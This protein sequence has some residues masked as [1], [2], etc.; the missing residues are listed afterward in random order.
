MKSLVNIIFTA[1][2]FLFCS[3]PSFSFTDVN[4][5]LTG[6]LSVGGKFYSMYYPAGGAGF[7]GYH[8]EI[9]GRPLQEIH[10]STIYFHHHNHIAHRFQYRSGAL[11]FEAAPPDTGYHTS[12]MLHF[13]VG[14]R[15]H[16][17]GF[18]SG[19]VTG[20]YPY[21]SA[22]FNGYNIEIGGDNPQ[23]EN[24]E[25]AIY[26]HD[27]YNVA[28]RLQY[29][30]GTL[31]FERPHQG[32]DWADSPNFNVEGS[33]T[34]S[35]LT[36]NG[37]ITA[38]GLITAGSYSCSDLRYKKDITGIKSALEK[39]AL[40]K[41]VYYNWNTDKYKQFSK[42]RDLGFIAQDVEKVIPEVV[43]TD[44][45]GY[46]SIAYSKMT[47]LLVE[48][49]KELKSENDR[50]KSKVAQLQSVKERLAKIE[51][52]MDSYQVGMW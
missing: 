14:G 5:L 50:L 38:T 9:G 3:V 15:I 25:A 40:L 7:N 24:H 52:K 31:F 6:N 47:A 46:K 29:R 22:S 16:G 39:V 21:G 42:K 10:E 44:K 32:Y 19:D 4:G 28:Y 13:Y 34:A 37:A 1:I 18:K 41:G 27:W 17:G 35:G 49:V 51:A 26:F 48:A 33:I 23:K 36:I 2:L 12:D 43:Y 8:I 20:K 45:K 30:N 11:F